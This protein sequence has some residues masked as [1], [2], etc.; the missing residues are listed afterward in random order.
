MIIKTRASL[1]EPVRAAVKD[2]IPIAPPPSSSCRSKAST[3]RIST[4][5]SIR[6]KSRRSRKLNLRR[7]IGAPRQMNARQRGVRPRFI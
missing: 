7:A 4:G 5:F 3:R 6:R 2:V 1:A